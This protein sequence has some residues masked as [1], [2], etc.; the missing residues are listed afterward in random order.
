MDGRLLDH[1]SR[2]GGRMPTHNEAVYRHNAR[3]RATTVAILLCAAFV[4]PSTTAA[5]RAAFD[6]S[7]NL[8]FVT[9]N[10]NCD[11]AY[12]FTVDI[13]DGRVTHPNLV[14]FAGH[15]SPSGRVRASVTVQDKYASGAG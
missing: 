6:G 7:W 12:N 15:V 14:R 10:G 13:T 8:A 4:C 3:A 11:Q 5:A 9:R 1:H 2:S